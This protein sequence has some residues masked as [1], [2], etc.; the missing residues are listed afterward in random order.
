MSSS[1]LS[2]GRLSRVISYSRASLLCRGSKD[3]GNGSSQLVPPAGFDGELFATPGGQAVELGAPVVLG[4]PVVERNPSSFDQ[5]MQR[6]VQGALLHLEHILG[7][8]LDGLGDCMAVSGSQ[9]QRAEDQQVQR[10]LQELDA[11]LIPFGRHSRWATIN[12]FTSN[13]KVSESRG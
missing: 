12:P 7:A 2:S 5:P 8:A 4:G 3:T 10:A 6:R 1:R 11:V 9:P 13:V